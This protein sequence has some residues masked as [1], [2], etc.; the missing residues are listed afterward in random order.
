MMQPVNGR[1]VLI[2]FHSETIYPVDHQMY[3]G[4]NGQI[5]DDVSSLMM[6]VSFGFNVGCNTR[7]CMKSWCDPFH[8]VVD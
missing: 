5:V 4:K 1:N 3:P 7:I 8:P 2:Y 6:A